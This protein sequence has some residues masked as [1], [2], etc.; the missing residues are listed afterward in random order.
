MS[1]ADVYIDFFERVLENGVAVVGG[2]DEDELA[3]SM[4]SSSPAISMRMR[5]RRTMPRTEAAVGEVGLPRRAN[6][7]NS[8]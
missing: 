5:A 1:P 4:S 7:P 2:L 8:A 6:S 3:S